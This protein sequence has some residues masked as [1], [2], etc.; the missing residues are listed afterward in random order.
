MFVYFLAR[1][2]EKQI[3]RMGLPEKWKIKYL[4][5]ERLGNG[6]DRQRSANLKLEGK[7]VNMLVKHTTFVKARRFCGDQA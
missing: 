1:I 2:T 7:T 5:L 3:C 4:S 6:I